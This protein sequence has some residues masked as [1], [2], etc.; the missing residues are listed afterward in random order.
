MPK[1]DTYRRFEIHSSLCSVWSVRRKDAVTRWLST[2]D[3]KAPYNYVGEYGEKDTT[4]PEWKKLSRAQK[5]A[6]LSRL[7]DPIS[8]GKYGYERL[9]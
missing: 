4:N 9:S 5:V 3:G 2:S 1:K 6:L 7:S 8:M